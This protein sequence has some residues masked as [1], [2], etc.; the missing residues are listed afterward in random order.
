LVEQNRKL[1]EFTLS[2][3]PAMPAGLAK[4][5]VKFVLDADGILQVKATELRSNVSQDIEVKPQYGL[6]DKQVEDM[7]LES[8]KNAKPDMDHRLLVEVQT[9]AEQMIY[10]T[11]QFLSKHGEVVNAEELEKTNGFVNQL[12]ETIKN[13]DRHIITQHIETL[14]EYTKPFA[15]RAMNIAVAASLKGKKI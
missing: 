10:L 2:G 4:I 7:L 6:T 14:N 8:L 15:E 11:E 3:I 1:A 9:E 13:K 5:E 12:K